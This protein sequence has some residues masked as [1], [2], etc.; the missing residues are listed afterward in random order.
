MKYRLKITGKILKSAQ[1]MDFLRM[2][3]TTLVFG[4]ENKIQ[5]DFLRNLRKKKVLFKHWYYHSAEGSERRTKC[6]RN[7]KIKVQRM[8]FQGHSSKK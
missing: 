4:S 3:V 8:S 5:K 7:L 6:V 1:Y 2:L